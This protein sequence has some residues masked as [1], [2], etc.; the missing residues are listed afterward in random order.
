MLLVS[1]KLKSADNTGIYW[2]RVL[3]ILGNLK[4]KIITLGEIIKVSIYKRT[5]FKTIIKKK[6]NFG[7]IISIN[8]EFRR[9]NWIFLKFDVNRILI[10]SDILKLLG[11]R[12]Y[13]PIPKEIRNSKKK[14]NLY[15]KIIS[16]SIFTV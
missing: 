10:L 6:I 8:K 12:V 7:L 14:R 15:R 16:Y 3:S 2:V 1:S 11:T 5:F 9:N 13:G 4:K